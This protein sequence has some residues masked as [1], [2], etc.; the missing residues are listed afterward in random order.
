MD[1]STPGSSQRWLKF[2]SIVSQRW[3][4]FMSI[5]SVM[6]SSHPLLPSS[7][8]FNLF[9]IRVFSS[10]SVLYIRRPQYWSFSLSISLSNEY[11]GLISFRVDSSDLPAI[12]ESSPGPQFESINSLVLSL[13]YGPAL[14]STWDY[15]KNNSFDYMYIFQFCLVLEDNSFKSKHSFIVFN[16]HKFDHDFVKSIYKSL[17]HLQGNIDSCEKNQSFKSL[18]GA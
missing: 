13:L 16:L 11:S 9:S 1:C 6:L 12:Q 18:R 14:T 8:P 3:L 7:F 17:S 10:E 4:K 15:W 5:G 2:M